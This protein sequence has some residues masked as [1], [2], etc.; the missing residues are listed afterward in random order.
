[1]KL[2]M[3][4]CKFNRLLLILSCMLLLSACSAAVNPAQTQD[5]TQSSSQGSAQTGT[6]AVE[7]TME[8]GSGKAT[9]ETP[10]M[11]TSDAQGMQAK[12]VWNS[13]NYDY[14]IVE[15]SAM[16]TRIRAV[17]LPSRSRL[18]RLMSRLR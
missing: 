9:I 13:K 6:F 16:R 8:G 7:I 1:M 3:S 18:Q 17:P 12:L 14:M 10:V 2:F 11:V 5:G 4:F 15:G